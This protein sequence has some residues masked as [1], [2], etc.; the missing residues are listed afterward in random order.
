M[1]GESNQ[2]TEEKI[3]NPIRPDPLFKDVTRRA[4]LAAGLELLDIE[5]PQLLRAD[6]VLA[7]PQDKDLSTTLFDFLFPYS[8]LEFKSENDTLDGSELAKNLARSLLFLSENRRA[9]YR[10]LLTVFIC[11]ERPDSLLEHF[12]LENLP[13]T[14]DPAQPWLLQAQFGP[15]QTVMVVCRLLPL[16]RKYYDWLLFAPATSRKWREFV[17]MLIR[18][19]EKALIEQVKSLR[20]KEYR[21]MTPELIEMLKD[22]SPEEREERNKDLLDLIES[23]VDMLEELNPKMADEFILNRF[24][25]LSPEQRKKLRELLGQTDN[26]PDEEKQK[27]E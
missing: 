1:S 25:K 8:I 5:L 2:P 23:E 22:L 6:L 11:A 21:L 27:P 4:A 15:L 18:N 9:S 17:K 13:V 20:L 7:V 19:G 14:T 26:Q 16:E 24:A 3:S 10:Q 12:R